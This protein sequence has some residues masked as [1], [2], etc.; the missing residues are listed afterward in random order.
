MTI[1]SAVVGAIALF[2]IATSAGA[3]AN[4]YDRYDRRILLVNR[5]HS[6]INE[7]FASNIDDR[8]WHDDLLE[9]DVLSPGQQMVLDLD[10]GS[11][12]CRFDLKTVMNDGS[13]VVRRGVD[14]CTVT[15]FTITD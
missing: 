15:T 2:S 14:I 9:D 6:T 11:G 5:S 8:R 12:Y 7:F 13:T 4:G 10:D 3:N 1:R